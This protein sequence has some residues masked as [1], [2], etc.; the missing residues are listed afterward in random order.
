MSPT[1]EATQAAIEH[2]DAVDQPALDAMRGNNGTSL[3]LSGFAQARKVAADRV[4]AAYLEDTRHFNTSELV[5]L[6]SV[7]RI[8]RAMGG[9]FLGKLLGFLP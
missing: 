4:R 6:M 8:R 7:D 5:E 3:N 9:T 2:F 1:F